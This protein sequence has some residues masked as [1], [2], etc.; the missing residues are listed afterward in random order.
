MPDPLFWDIIAIPV[1]IGRNR[2]RHMQSRLLLLFPRSFYLSRIARRTTPFAFMQ[3]RQCR[4]QCRATVFTRVF[5]RARL[6]AGFA[7][8][9]LRFCKV[10]TAVIPAWTMLEKPEL[11]SR[12]NLFL[13]LTMARGG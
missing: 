1:P 4:C 2:D 5:P 13:L 11:V 8:I 9:S 7:K 12:V 3:N 6:I 10:A